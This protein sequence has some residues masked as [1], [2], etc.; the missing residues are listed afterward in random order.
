MRDGRLHETYWN[1]SFTPIIDERGD[2]V[3]VLNQ[4]N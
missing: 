2:V 1:Y 4:G 3:G